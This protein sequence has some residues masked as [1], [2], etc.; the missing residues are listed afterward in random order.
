MTFLVNLPARERAEL[1]GYW[2]GGVRILGGL[3]ALKEIR[4]GQGGRTT[5]R[6]LILPIASRDACRVRGAGLPNQPL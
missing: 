4:L 5:T 6:R 3:R 2:M 1:D